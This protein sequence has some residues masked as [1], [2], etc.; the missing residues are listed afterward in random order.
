L[1][2][3]YAKDG[4]IFCK[5]YSEIYIPLNYFEDKFAIDQGSSI[6][7]I[8]ILYIKSFKDGEESNI[9][10]INIPSVIN[11]MR[12]DFIE[13]EI[14]IKGKK[15]KVMVLKYLPDSYMFHQSVE[16]GRRVA[17]IFLNSLLMGKLPK[18]LDYSQLI[19]IWWKNIAIAGVS[20]NVP[21][22]IFELI[23][24]NIYR[25]PTDFKKR[26]SEYYGKQSNPNP[27]SYQ[28]GNVRDIVENLSTFSSIIFEDVARMLTSGIVNSLEN[29]EEP[30]SPLE[31]I[32]YY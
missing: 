10:L 2:I 12:Y 3:L 11:V 14:K 19:D 20:L 21:S 1:S 22:K 9:Q 27:Y 24:A 13:D 7:T 15:I 25:D 8:G 18:T 4:K 31:K 6:E 32:I 17:E 5:Y 16:S 30:V 28:T 26:F 29:V 23:I